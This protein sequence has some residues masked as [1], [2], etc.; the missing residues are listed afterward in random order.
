MQ[1][2]PALLIKSFSLTASQT[3]VGQLFPC[4]HT[5]LILFLRFYLFIHERQRATERQAE[6]EAGSMQGA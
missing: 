3:E 6:G 5:K 1:V 2:P 4:G